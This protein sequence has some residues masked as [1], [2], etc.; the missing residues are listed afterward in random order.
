MDSR[1]THTYN[2]SIDELI[3]K[4]SFK[5]NPDNK[6]KVNYV[7]IKINDNGKMKPLWIQTSNMKAPFGIT[8]FK[9]NPLKTLR[10]SFDNYKNDDNV[11]KFHDLM[12]QINEKIIQEVNNNQSWIKRKEK[13][14][15]NVIKDNY[16]DIVQKAKKN[17]EETDEYP[18]NMNLKLPMKNNNIITKVYNKN[19]QLQIGKI[20]DLITPK[21]KV[22]CLI[23]CK[24]IW[25]NGMG[26]FGVTWNL[27]QVK[28][29]KP[30]EDIYPFSDTDDEN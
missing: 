8:Q 10:I 15:L 16:T 19:K 20:E 4:L 9:D 2:D 11:K 26:R 24:G 30:I 13:V 29:E 27:I 7:S 21:S 28:C 5:Y 1:Y 17:G 22:K 23:E 12:T 3:N 18:P 25:I 14:S 6:G